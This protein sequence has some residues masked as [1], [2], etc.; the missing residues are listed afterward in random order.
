M[1]PNDC[2][3]LVQGIENYS[4]IALLICEQQEKC[5]EKRWYSVKTRTSTIRRS[6]EEKKN[7]H[8]TEDLQKKPYKINTFPG[9]PHRKLDILAISKGYQNKAGNRMVLK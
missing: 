5:Q 3:I 9:Q 1:L 8:Y 7:N 4:P 6:L 2:P